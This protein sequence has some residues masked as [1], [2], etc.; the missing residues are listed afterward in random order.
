MPIGPEAGAGSFLAGEADLISA[1]PGAVHTYL[2]AVDCSQ[3]G[4]AAPATP[5]E[6]AT[7]ATG[8]IRAIALN[9]KLS[10][11]KAECTLHYN[12]DLHGKSCVSTGADSRLSEQSHAH[13]PRFKTVF[14]TLGKDPSLFTALA[15]IRLNLCCTVLTLWVITDRT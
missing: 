5:G 1:S 2:L 6:P 7:R 10:I 15:G 12:S 14:V 9:S 3:C 8:A 4:G 11:G 13:N